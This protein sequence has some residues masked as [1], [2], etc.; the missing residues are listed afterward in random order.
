[1]LEVRPLLR[2]SAARRTRQIPFYLVRA[3]TFVET[4]DIPEII[5]PL[6]QIVGADHLRSRPR[7]KSIFKREPRSVEL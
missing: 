2:S 1:V 7:P 4:Y 6:Q 5:E 3:S